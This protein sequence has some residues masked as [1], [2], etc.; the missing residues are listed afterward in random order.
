MIKGT[1][2]VVEFDQFY[3]VTP[4]IDGPLAGHIFKRHSDGAE[5][6]TYLNPSTGGDSGPDSFAYTGPH[7]DPCADCAEVFIDAQDF[8]VR[9]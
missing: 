2:F 8:E 7:G 1:P 9:A 5:T 6:R 4:F 3:T